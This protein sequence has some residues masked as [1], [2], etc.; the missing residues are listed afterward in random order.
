MTPDS[1][2]PADV[3]IRVT[4]VSKT[5]QVYARPVDMLLE[6]L[7]GRPRHTDFHAL[8]DIS[9]AVARGE[10]VGIIGSNGAGKSTLLKILAGTLDKTSGSIE[11]AGRIS[12]IL[13]LGTGFHPEYSGRENVILGGMCLGMSRRE[14]EQKAPSIIAFSELGAVIDQP[15]KT[16]SSGMQ[17]RL[18][19]ST[20]ISIEPEILIIDEALAAGDAYFVSKCMQRI[21][22][23]C[24]SGAT[25]LFVSHSS[26]LIAEMCHRA[27]WVEQGRIRSIGDAR[28][29]VKAYEFETWRRVEQAAGA[30]NLDRARELLDKPGP[31]SAAAQETDVDR[32]VATGKYDLGGEEARITAVSLSNQDGPCTLFTADDRMT[33]TITWTGAPTAERLW[34]GLGI[35]SVAKPIIFGYESWADG[36]FIAAAD[37]ARGGG[38]VSLT[39]EHLH[40][41][42]GEYHVSVSLSKY[43]QPWSKESTL[44][45]LEKVCAFHVKRRQ[46]APAMLVYDPPVVF[47]E[48]DYQPEP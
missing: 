44:H 36:R 37:A 48:G 46:L 43:M 17:A 9:F 4:G 11:V 19:F 29:V 5:Y 41:G 1:P 3:A 16:Y 21:R 39:I 6:A 31:S 42:P 33:V 14:V 7:G 10:V 22:A 47:Q 38:R 13:E 28:N 23:I 32:V 25:V 24:E 40:L 18:T 12:A 45:R 30:Q 35:G 34:V 15:F 26:L 8:H 27:I 2:P 20:A